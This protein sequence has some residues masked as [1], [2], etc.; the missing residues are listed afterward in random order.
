MCQCSAYGVALPRD[1]P[2][3]FAP[4]EDIGGVVV[5]MSL[6]EGGRQ[7]AIVFLGTILAHLDKEFAEGLGG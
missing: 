3:R 1:E 6:L 2:R 4:Y 7:A 5:S